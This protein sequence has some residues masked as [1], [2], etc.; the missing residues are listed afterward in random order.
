MEV[1]VAAIDH[2]ISP[3]H[4]LSL[5]GTGKQFK[6]LRSYVPALFILVIIVTLCITITLLELD[7]IK[8][9]ISVN[10]ITSKYFLTFHVMLLLQSIS[11]FLVCIFDRHMHC[12]A[13][14]NRSHGYIGFYGNTRNIRRIPSYCMSAGCALGLLLAAVWGDVKPPY[15][16]ISPRLV[17]LVVVW[18]ETLLSCP[19]IIWYVTLVFKHNLHKALPDMDHYLRPNGI[20]QSARSQSA[21]AETVDRQGDIIRSL[22]SHNQVL[23]RRIMALHKQ[24]NEVK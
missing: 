18:L 20:Q 2:E 22:Q 6:R 13:S 1:G 8:V 11:W 10:P 4:D 7:V 15:H 14:K 3:A 9:E 5:L 23:A 16:N 19:A 24:V 17:M 21:L 12:L